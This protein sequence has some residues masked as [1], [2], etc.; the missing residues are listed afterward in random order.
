MAQLGSSQDAVLRSIL[1]LV[2]GVDEMGQYHKDLQVGFLNFRRHFLVLSSWCQ[3]TICR[4]ISCHTTKTSATT[5]WPTALPTRSC[6]ATSHVGRIHWY[7]R[8]KDQQAH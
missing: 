2:F 3:P 8:L 5:L 7:D 1:L 6:L 4:V